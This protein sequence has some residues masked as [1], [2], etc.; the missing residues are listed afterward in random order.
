MFFIF[1]YQYAIMQLIILIGMIA[2]MTVYKMHHTQKATPEEILNEAFKQQK[3]GFDAMVKYQDRVIT[4][5]P[6]IFI[7][8]DVNIFSKYQCCG[9]NGAG[10]YAEMKLP[11]SCSDKNHNTYP[12]CLG[13][14]KTKAEE[15]LEAPQFIGWALMVVQVLD[16]FIF[17]F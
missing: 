14:M 7:V 9:I 5:N 8:F 6:L 17:I 15:D 3:D 12:G 11:K 16:F 2:V 10:D 4:Q 1:N 13:K